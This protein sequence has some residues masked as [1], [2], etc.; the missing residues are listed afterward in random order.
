MSVTIP[1]TF[2]GGAG[3]KARASEVNANFT[4]VAAKF[5]E[6]AGGIA[7]ADIATI[8]G[9]RAIKLSTTIGSRITQAQLEDNAVTFR[10]LLSEASPSTNAAVNTANHIKDG[11][12]T[13]AKLV[14]A[15]IAKDRLKLANFVITIPVIAAELWTN[16]DSTLFSTSAF[17]ISMVVEQDPS[18][19]TVHPS[20]TL[21]LD[22]ATNKYWIYA[23]NGTATPTIAYSVRIHYLQLT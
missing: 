4:A 7:D 15:T 22:I 12:I 5:S 20:L 11:I 21:L 6:G 17:P 18:V 19:N 10:A 16:V 2:V 23:L 14:A 9:I 1:Y 8:A 13:G 3:N